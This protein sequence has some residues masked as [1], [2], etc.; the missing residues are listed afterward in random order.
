MSSASADKPE[1]RLLQRRVRVALGREPGDL[2]LSGG[3]VVNVFT[4][5]VEPANV[6]IADGWIAGVGPY[7]WPAD[8]TL[9]LSGPAVLPGLIDAHMHLE[10]TLLLPAELTKLIVP[11]GTTAVV[12]DPHEIANV[13]GLEGVRLLIDA[14]AGLPLDVFFM[15]PSC[16]PASAA[17]SAGAVL[18]AAA[19]ATLLDHPRVLG[20][21]EMMNFPGV[22][23]GD[24]QVLQKIAASLGRGLPVDGHAPGLSGQELAAYAAAGI[25]SDHECST[26]EEALAKAALGMMVQV[27]EGSAARNLDTFLPLLVEDRLGDWC[28]ATD[29]IHVDDLMDAGHL[30]VLLRR[31]VGAG[32]PAAR[33]VRHATLAPARHYGLNDRGAVAPG[34][35]ADLFIVEDLTGFKPHTTIKDGKVV[36]RDGG[37]VA[38]LDRPRIPAENTVHLGSLDEAVFELCPRDSRCPVIGLV[39]DEILTRHESHNVRRDSSTGRWVFEADRDICLVACLERHEGTSRVGVGLVRGFGLR[40]AGAFGSSVAH[41]AH[42]LLLA[43]TNPGDMLACA[44]ALEETGG[45]FVVVSDRSVVARLPLQL[46]GLMSTEAYPTVRRRLDEVTEAVRNLGCSLPAPFGTLSFLGLSV[47]PELR[48]TDRGVYDVLQQKIITP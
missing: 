11:R 10:S 39:P 28:L 46:A 25:R 20:L 8:E 37:F 19:V 27:R 35:R 15:A 42:N 7:D 33:A 16:V 18:D 22:L 36:A 4:R 44:R 23:G 40:S 43:G 26:V 29:D 2:V 21:A 17:E 12:A 30:D 6:V 5:Q 48:I 31:L 13:A 41:D 3:Q 38:N 14:S 32:V 24:G 45:G 34:Y 1:V 47:I 9:A